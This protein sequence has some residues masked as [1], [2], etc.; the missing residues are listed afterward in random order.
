[1]NNILKLVL[2]TVPIAGLG[3]GFL[4]YT[5]SN[6]PPPDHHGLAERAIHVSVIRAEIQA[7]TP[8]T[9]GF[10]RVEPARVYEAITQVAGTADYVNPAL[11]RGEILPEGSVLLR[12]SPADFNLAI[13][14]SRTSIR[15]AEARLKELAVTEANYRAS[16]EIEHQT[17][18]LK[19]QEFSRVESL[20]ET[21]TTS[22]AKRDEGHAAVLAQ[23]Q[24]VQGIESSIALLPTQRAVLKEQIAA[25]QISLQQAELNLA[26][27]SV[28]LPYTARV[29]SVA[30]ETG[31]F[32]RA[33]STVATLVG[34]DAAE[35][36][37]QI[38]LANLRN[39]LRLTARDSEI[40]PMDP[41]A[42]AET[43][44]GLDLTATVNLNLGRDTVSWIATVD[45]LSDTIDP[46]TGAVGVIVRVENAYG[47]ADPGNRPP[48]TQGM[49]V[50][51]VLTAPPLEG[52]LL[53]RTALRDGSV[54][55]A[56]EEDRLQ[57]VPVTPRF[58]QDDI[59]VVTEGL[60]AG[61]RVLVVPPTPVIEGMLL[62]TH[63]D[64]ALMAAMGTVE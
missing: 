24:K 17:L 20:F 37:A 22:R 44:R 56:D 41:S 43:I 35:V 38:N 23:R 39:L 45:R 21:G 15:T 47:A 33:G 55:V 6:S 40:P 1:M 12:L 34:V 4:A 19:E 48:L 9:S 13:A 52:L 10:G 5:V 3:A 64:E 14:Q 42:M 16:L 51:V 54:L 63:L 31:E 18:A 11:R 50:E 26:R 7:V 59:L 25:S 58:V 2:I 32:V 62:G 60:K 46:R 61:A 36:E 49:F 30:V 8:A 29:S 57:R 28:A 27:T 53:P